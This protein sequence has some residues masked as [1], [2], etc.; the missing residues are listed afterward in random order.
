[1]VQ[2]PWKKND[3]LRSLEEEEEGEYSEEEEVGDERG[4]YAEKKHEDV[5]GYVPTSKSESKDLRSSEKK[6]EVVEGEVTGSFHFDEIVNLW[7]DFN[8]V[9][10]HHKTVVR[11]IIASL[12]LYIYIYVCV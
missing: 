9:H 6:T 12:S 5:P 7:S 2:E 1:V 4:G 3:F 10:Y 11:T 8:K